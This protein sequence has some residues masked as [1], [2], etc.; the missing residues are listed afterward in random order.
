[1]YKLNCS[2]QRYDWGKLGQNSKVAIY[3]SSQET[4]FEIK[5]NQAYA[6]LW[7][8]NVKYFILF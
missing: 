2:V 5:E 1:M 8:G 6:E 7:M 4:D 3:K